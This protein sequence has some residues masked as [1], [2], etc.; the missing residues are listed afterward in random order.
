MG[1]LFFDCNLSM[2]FLMRSGE[3]LK[4]VFSLVPILSYL[5]IL[6]GVGWK[7]G[8]FFIGVGI[9]NLTGVGYWMLIYF[10]FTILGAWISILHFLAGGLKTF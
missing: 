8:I 7:M 4:G 9:L 2:Q 6:V 1:D 10:T 5:T 3:M